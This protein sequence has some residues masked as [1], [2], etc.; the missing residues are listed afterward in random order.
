[1]GKGEKEGQKKAQALVR[2]W[3]PR[4]V[5]KKGQRGKVSG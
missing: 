3:G 5:P 1:V 4:Q 2:Y